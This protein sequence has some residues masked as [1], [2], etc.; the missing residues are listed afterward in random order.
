MKDRM[1]VEL[2]TPDII[3]CDTNYCNAVKDGVALYRDGDHLSTFG[4]EYVSRTFDEV[5][6]DSAKTIAGQYRQIKVSNVLAESPR[7]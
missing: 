2:I 6:I 1:S 7:H 4:S 5:L 3:L